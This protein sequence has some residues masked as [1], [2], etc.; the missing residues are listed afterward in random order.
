MVLPYYWSTWSLSSKS[1]CI[2]S[3]RDYIF[4]ITCI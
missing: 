3:I 2:R 4:S 1:N